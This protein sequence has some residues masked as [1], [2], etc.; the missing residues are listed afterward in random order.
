MTGTAVLRL[1]FLVSHD[2]KFK[3]ESVSMIVSKSDFFG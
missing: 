3:P 1:F 2:E